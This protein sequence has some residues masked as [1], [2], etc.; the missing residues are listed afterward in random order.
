MSRWKKRRN[1]STYSK[2]F[3]NNAK[4]R[5]IVKARAKNYVLNKYNNNKNFADKVRFE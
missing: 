4:F 3:H 2:K 5:D 1:K